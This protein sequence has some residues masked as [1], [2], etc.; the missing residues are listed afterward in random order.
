MWRGEVVFQQIFKLVSSKR[1]TV[2]PSSYAGNALTQ[3]TMISQSHHKTQTSWYTRLIYTVP[4][5][6]ITPNYTY[7]TLQL[8]LL[9]FLILSIIS[10]SPKN[11]TDPLCETLWYF[12]TRQWVKSKNPV[13]LPLSKH[14]GTDHTKRSV[15]QSNAATSITTQ[16]LHMYLLAT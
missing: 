7:T 4:S 10:Y 1:Y 11:R 13:I 2:T 14:S 12:N 6:Q 5:N 8:A 15:N 16:Y 9:G 3:R